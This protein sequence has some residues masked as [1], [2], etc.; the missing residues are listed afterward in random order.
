MTAEYDS[1]I[2]Y[3]QETTRLNPMNSDA[4]NNLGLAWEEKGDNL[5]A[6]KYYQKAIEVDPDNKLAKENLRRVQ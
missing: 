5:N 2:Y 6:K 3:F 1:A 4:F